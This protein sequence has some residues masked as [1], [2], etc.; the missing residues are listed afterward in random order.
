[1]PFTTFFDEYLISMFIGLDF[2]YGANYLFVSFMSAS[3]SFAYL[4][5]GESFFIFI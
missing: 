2:S 1:L 5:H 3:S 4:E